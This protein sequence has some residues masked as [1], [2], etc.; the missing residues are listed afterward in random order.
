[1]KLNTVLSAV[2][3]KLGVDINSASAQTLLTNQNLST[4]DVSEDVA[5][6]LSGDFYTVESAIQHPG[7]RSKIKAEVLNGIDAQTK[8]LMSRYELDTDTQNEILAE[9]KSAKKLSKLVDKVAELSRTKS[10]STNADKESLNLEIEKL[11]KQIVA[12][13]QEYEDKVT[14]LGKARKMDKL[15][16]ELDSIYSGLD[17]SFDMD[18]ELAITAA[19]SVMGRIAESKGLRFETTENGIQILTKEGT[20]YFEN[21]SKPA[22]G[23]FIKKSLMENKM[24][25]V[26]TAQTAARPQQ[27]QTNT[28]ATARKDSNFMKKLDAKIAEQQ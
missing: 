3:T 5:D 28:P 16:W 23:D 15:N 6:K 21:N 4:I 27:T 20:E 19:K 24:I 14:E 18:K 7:I 17:F 2:L 22:I 9:D 10:K 12:T 25:K 8:D 11:N 13:R 26:A 1:M